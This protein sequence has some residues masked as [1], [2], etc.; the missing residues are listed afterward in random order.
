ML[1][2]KLKTLKQQQKEILKNFDII[3]LNNINKQIYEINQ[4]IKQEKQKQF[5]KMREEKTNEKINKILLMQ[6]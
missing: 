1:L 4:Q 2:E 6:V 5:E 3:K